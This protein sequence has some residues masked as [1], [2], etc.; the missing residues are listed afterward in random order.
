MSGGEGREEGGDIG[1]GAFSVDC[2]FLCA[3]LSFSM[4]QLGW[5]RLL[6]LMERAGELFSILPADRSKSKARDR[7]SPP[8]APPPLLTDGSIRE[9]TAVWGANGGRRA[10][11]ATGRGVGERGSPRPRLGEAAEKDLHSLGKLSFKKSWH[12]NR[13]Y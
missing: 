10:I 8:P 1:W 13:E 6:E 9:S 7:G 3:G 2:V 12:P 4:L 5:G 11:H